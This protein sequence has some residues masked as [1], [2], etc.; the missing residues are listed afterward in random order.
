[1]SI[2]LI[3]GDGPEHRY[4]A[5]TILERHNIAQIFICDPPKRRSW[6]TVFRRSK[7]RFVDKVLRKAYLTLIRDRQQR[8]TSLAEVL[9]PK[10]MAFHRQDILTRVGLPKAGVLEQ[11]VAEI[12]PEIIAV[13]GTGIIPQDV[14]DLANTVAL[15]MHTGLSPWYR[16]VSCAL[17]PIID[18]KPEMVGATIHECTSVVDGGRIF[19]RERAA[20]HVTDDLHAIFARAVVAGAKGYSDVLSQARSGALVGDIQDS[21]IGKEYR[22]DM[23]G[24]GVELRARRALRHVF[25]NYPRADGGGDFD[26]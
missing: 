5:N 1:M 4:V 16:G 18:G 3:T 24:L 13:Y 7:R 6:K 21:N 23:L 9:G 19:Q 2:V 22:G 14:L 10:S 20:L 15:N 17:W 11:K 12:A 25:D 26:T 8:Q